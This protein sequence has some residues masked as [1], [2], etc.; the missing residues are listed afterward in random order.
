MHC[1]YFRLS[2]STYVYPIV[3]TQSCRSTRGKHCYKRS[4]RIMV[5]R[6]ISD[7][8]PVATIVDVWR[9]ANNNQYTFV[10]KMH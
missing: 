4:Q 9:L 5:R 8:S 3:A 6:R 1:S 10:T 2:I 7:V